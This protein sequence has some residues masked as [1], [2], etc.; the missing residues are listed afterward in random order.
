MGGA[1]TFALPRRTDDGRSRHKA[2][3]KAMIRQVARQPAVLLLLAGA[4]VSSG[5]CTLKEHHHRRLGPDN[6]RLSYSEDTDLSKALNRK[7]L[8][9]G[10][11]ERVPAVLLLH[12]IGGA[13]PETLELG[14]RLRAEGYT[15]YVPVLFGKVGE[16]KP[17]LL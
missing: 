5:C 8:R 9:F 6:S 15:V 4:F 11:V 17:N 12:E 10:S 2:G 7:V 16:R 1:E 14:E 3:G 13:T